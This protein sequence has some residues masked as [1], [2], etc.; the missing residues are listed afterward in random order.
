MPPNKKYKIR[1][2]ADRTLGPL[3]F[4]R[5]QALVKK[6]HIQGQELTASEPYVDWLPFVN[7]PELSE[8]LVAKLERDGKAPTAPRA[9]APEEKGEPAAAPTMTMV[10]PKEKDTGSV[11][12]E[13]ITAEEARRESMRGLTE[14]QR[15]AKA[16]QDFM[17]AVPTLVDVIAPPKEENPDFEPTQM[18]QLPVAAENHLPAETEFQEE[19]EGGTKILRL[20]AV[21][22]ALQ[23]YVPDAAVAKV[24]PKE[25]KP[26]DKNI[27]GQKVDVSQYVTETGKRRLISRNMAALIALSLLLLSYFALQDE[28]AAD[29]NNIMLKY[30]T[31]PYVEVNVPARM[32]NV[33]DAATSSDLME[34][35]VRVMNQ[36][37]PSSYIRAI[38]TFLYPSVGKN[39]R[40][41]DARALLAS[42][43]IRL[44]EIVPRDQRLFDTVEKLLFPGPAETLQTPEYA[45]A[46]AEYYQMLNR[47]DQA[48]EVIDNYLKRRPTLE[49]LYQKAKIAYERRDI[50]V[51][52]NAISK[53][54]PPEKVGKANPRHHLLYAMLLEKRG[55]KDA[56][57]NA[58]KRLFAEYP[59][60]GP[61]LLFHADFLLRNGKPK[62]AQKILKVLMERPFLM[63]RMQQADAMLVT[64]R[65]FEALNQMGKALRFAQAAEKFHYSSEA[66]Q[67]V[68][69]R[70][71]SKLPDTKKAYTLII[72][73]RQ[74]ERAKQ[75]EQAILTYTQALEADRSDSTV[76]MLLGNLF[77]ERG[78]IYDA[79][80]RYQKALQRTVDK[81]VEAAINLARIFAARYELEKA[82]TN[83]KIASEKRTKLDQVDYLR[84]VVLVKQRRPDLAEPYFD[85]AL[86]RGSRLVDLY[87]T[88][89][90]LQTTL[91]NEKLAEFYYSTALRYEP[92]NAKAMLGTALARFHLDSPSRA[93]TFLKDKLATQPNSAAIM[94]NLAI[95]YLRSGDQD[96]GK[97][98]LQNAIR[99]DSRYAEAFRLL[100]DLTKDEGNRQTDYGARRNSYRYAL[101]SYEMYSRLAP[102]DPEGYKATGDLYFDIR[103]LG[104]AAKN[105][106]KV[107]DLTSNYPDVRLRLAQI[108]RNGGDASKAMELLDKEIEI[109]PRSDAAMVEKGNIFMAKK[110]FDN[111]TRSFTE[112][113]RINDKNSDALFGLGVVY[114]LQGSY[115]NALSLFARVIKLDPLKADVYWQM[116]LI[117]Q[118]QNNRSKAMQA[119]TDYKGIV[120]EPAA[121]VKADEKMRELK[122]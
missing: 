31:F 15:E 29:P 47:Y 30:H 99:S 105:Y 118:K 12:V 87:L 108:S 45:V 65:C 43:Y 122:R 70:V 38:K 39:Q 90:E 119:F 80:D 111:A 72:S 18:I 117:Y 94:T 121:L 22:Q 73:A 24:A 95:I 57:G 79:I 58:L 19:S 104:A 76:F 41:F 64:A 92:Y 35:G 13:E 115:D 82:N 25:K 56:A 69:F 60:N 55:Q 20:D 16:E 36:E 11:N 23:P 78:D 113:A 50:D 66:V 120:R 48:Q 34:K 98:Y 3:D 88:E 68:L 51:A 4:G 7:F 6:G 32:G 81:P 71:K 33:V 89:G 109:N 27:F 74:K 106:Y 102:N 1:L 17:G 83:I 61:A 40:N 9:S 103:D 37:T 59:A 44:S 2:N 26:A 85:K 10:A 5:V 77:E 46:L 107:L 53:A 84:G 101:A 62:E 93:L 114:H 8:L 100:G 21:D 91:K 63:D 110:E 54:I 75:M 112:A 28:E 49:L 14:E 116:G 67:D 96:S 86:G 97:N 52:L 42:A